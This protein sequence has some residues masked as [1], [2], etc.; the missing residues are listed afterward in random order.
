VQPFDYIS[1]ADAGA[2]IDR[3]GGAPGTAFIAGGTDLMQLMKEGAAAPRHLIDINALPLTE[4]RV[5]P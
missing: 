1:V 3:A 4:I 2:A 5:G